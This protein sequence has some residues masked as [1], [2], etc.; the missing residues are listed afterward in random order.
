MLKTYETK[1]KFDYS[2]EMWVIHLIDNFGVI[3]EI[4]T[5][6]THPEALVISQ[7]MLKDQKTLEKAIGTYGMLYTL[8]EFIERC[9]CGL[10]TEYD[11]TGEY[12]DGVLLS[13]EPAYPS[14]I[15][16][17]DIDRFYTHVVWYNK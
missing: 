17:G 13:G 12:S 16:A 5:C 10:F 15:F 8:D 7:H 4:K 9:D 6:Y 2:T 14:E 1:V 3:H 11:G